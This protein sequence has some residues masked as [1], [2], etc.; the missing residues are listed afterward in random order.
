MELFCHAFSGQNL[1]EELASLHGSHAILC[2][3]RRLFSRLSSMLA[4]SRCGVFVMGGA[5]MTKEKGFSG[6]NFSFGRWG[7]GP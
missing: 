5:E 6:L 7:C 1:F 2:R 3:C 4:V